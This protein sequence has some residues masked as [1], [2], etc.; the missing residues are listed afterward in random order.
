M[1]ELLH[2]YLGS[3]L[4]STFLTQ[5]SLSLPL[6]TGIK[7]VKDGFPFSLGIR[8]PK[9]GSRSGSQVGYGIR[10]EMELILSKPVLEP[11][12]WVLSDSDFNRF[13]CTYLPTHIKF[14]KN[15]PPISFKHNPKNSL[16]YKVADQEE[17]ENGN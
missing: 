11:Q 1:Q 2:Y 5:V 10:T 13:F 7:A 17:E 14:N 6:K 12:H 15:G 9:F 4:I 16:K 3:A 8:H